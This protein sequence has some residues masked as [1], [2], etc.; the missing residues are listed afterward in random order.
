M[1]GLSAKVRYGL[2]AAYDLALH[3]GAGPRQIRDIASFQ[4]IPHQ[5]LEQLLV[6]LKRTGLVE[7][8]RGSQGGYTLAR[9][10]AAISVLQV[11]ICLDGQLSLAIGEWMDH[12]LRSQL[13]RL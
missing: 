8:F 11:L 3:L 4:H 10:P 12:V 7:S 1:T 5:F 6:S 2:Q 13:E 9:D